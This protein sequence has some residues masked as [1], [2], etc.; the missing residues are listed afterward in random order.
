M[1]F[2]SH[3]QR[4]NTSSAQLLSTGD[5]G[6]KAFNMCVLGATIDYQWKEF[7]GSVQYKCFLALQI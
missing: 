5:E 7:Q 3:M 4:G 1:D 2:N 6:L